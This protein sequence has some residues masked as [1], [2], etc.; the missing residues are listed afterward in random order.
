MWPARRST[1]TPPSNPSLATVPTA[2]AVALWS[3]GVARGAAPREPYCTGSRTSGEGRYPVP[4]RAGRCVRVRRACGGY[5]RMRFELDRRLRSRRDGDGDQPGLSRPPA[6]SSLPAELSGRQVTVSS[7]SPTLRVRAAARAGRGPAPGSSSVTAVARRRPTG[8]HDQVPA[9]RRR[10]VGLSG[11]AGPV[12]SRPG[13][14]T[15]CQVAGDARRRDR[16]PQLGPAR[17]VPPDHL[18]DALDEARARGLREVEA[19]AEAVGVEADDRAGGVEEGPAGGATRHRRRVLDAAADRAPAGAAEAPPRAR[20]ES[21]RQARAGG[22]TREPEHDRA[23]AR[24]A[25]SPL[26]QLHDHV[27][28]EAPP[29]QAVST[30]IARPGGCRARG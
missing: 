20:H 9:P 4:G 8:A 5:D 10:S 30:A 16:D 6:S 14:P 3:T 22:A 29:G 25:L 27:D 19:L 18:R 12:L 17:D 26:D 1:R 21:G 13:R 28:L 24:E 23:D 7:I 15:E 2:E 11:S